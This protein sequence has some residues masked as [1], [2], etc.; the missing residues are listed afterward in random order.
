MRIDLFSSHVYRLRIHGLI[1]S[2]KDIIEFA[3]QAVSSFSDD[4]AFAAL[5]GYRRRGA[6]HSV[7]AHIIQTEGQYHFFLD[8]ECPTVQGRELS[9]LPREVL[10][11]T[12]Q[13]ET[14]FSSDE[15]SNITSEFHCDASFQYPEDEVSTLLPLP[16][17]T[18]TDSNLPFS[19]VRGI[20]FVKE[21][22]EEHLYSVAL[23]RFPRQ[24]A[25][26]ASVQFRLEGTIDSSFPSKYLT[27]A[28][29]IVNKFISE[30]SDV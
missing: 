18:T 25:I 26:R 23:D 9:N 20:R 29:F 1:M 7:Y 6:I 13:L 2:D 12:S 8:Y 28:N 4:D 17:L 15:F 22:N 27:N 3:K 10:S 30:I 21:T 16:L 14:L 19:Q 5:A 24:Q 11:V